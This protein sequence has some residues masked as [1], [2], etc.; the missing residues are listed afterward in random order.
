MKVDFLAKI[1]SK[2]LL[3]V[4]P[5]LNMSFIR[6]HVCQTKIL[7]AK[8]TKKIG[9]THFMFSWVATEPLY[10]TAIPSSHQHT[11]SYQLIDLKRVLRTPITLGQRFIT[12]LQD[13]NP[14]NCPYKDRTYT[15]QNERMWRTFRQL[16]FL[17]SYLQPYYNNFTTES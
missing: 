6:L 7:T 14:I 15:Q 8:T 10:F 11:L 3:K 9:P 13:H 17:P 5:C 16:N 2:I 4:I 1:F 12:T